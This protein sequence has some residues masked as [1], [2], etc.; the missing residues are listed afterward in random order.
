[1]DIVERLR[2]RNVPYGWLEL[3]DKA[4]DEIGRLRAALK[5][6]DRSAGLRSCRSSLCVGVDCQ[7]DSLPPQACGSYKDRKI[8]YIPW[9]TLPA[10]GSGL[11]G[12][13]QTPDRRIG[14]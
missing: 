9:H 10:R 6:P 4:A 2:V 3:A 12:D 11:D 13:L 7:S 1:M 8:G 14:Q 5:G